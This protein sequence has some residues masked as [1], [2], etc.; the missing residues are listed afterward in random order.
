MRGPKQKTKQ[1][2]FSGTSSARL[3]PRGQGF[4]LGDTTACGGRRYQPA[5]G[6][7]PRQRANRR[8]A[9][10]A[11]RHV[12][13]KA[14][15]QR[16]SSGARRRRHQS[17][18]YQ[19]RHRSRLEQKHA[20]E[21]QRLLSTISEQVNPQ[22]GT[23]TIGTTPSNDQQLEIRLRPRSGQRRQQGYDYRSSHF[24]VDTPVS[25]CATRGGC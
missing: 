20:A 1:K 14:N 9:A 23:A 12:R 3:E 18:R 2:S 10:I 7:R 6:H 16:R 4:S 22:G 13:E 8:V 19:R 15:E 21:C 25:C 5:L 17:D 11:A 24:G